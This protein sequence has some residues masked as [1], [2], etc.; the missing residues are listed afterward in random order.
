V[1]EEI[2]PHTGSLLRLRQPQEI[3][4]ERGAPKPRRSV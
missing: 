4:H 1:I 2:K 3:L